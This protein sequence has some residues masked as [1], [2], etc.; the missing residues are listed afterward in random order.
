MAGASVLMLGWLSTSCSVCA[1]IQAAHVFLPAA[2]IA[3]HKTGFGNPTWLET[4][5]VADVTSPAVTALL[6]AGAVVRDGSSMH[7]MA[8]HASQHIRTIGM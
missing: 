4:H 7:A 5:P 6:E 3:G 2:Q 8:Q 1:C